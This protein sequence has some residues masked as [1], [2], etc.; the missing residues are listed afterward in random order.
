MRR[1]DTNKRNSNN[2]SHV[3]YF[4]N[5]CFNLTWQIFGVDGKGKYN[6]T[7]FLRYLNLDCTGGGKDCPKILDIVTK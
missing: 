6:T 3:C 5:I 2:V 4:C 7:K 1:L